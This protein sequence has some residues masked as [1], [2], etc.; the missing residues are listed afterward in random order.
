MLPDGK[1]MVAFVLTMMSDVSDAPIWLCQTMSQLRPV[2]CHMTV[3]HQLWIAMQLQLPWLL[4]PTSK[5]NIKDKTAEA[6]QFHKSCKHVL[7]ANETYQ[8]HQAS[9][10]V[11]FAAAVASRFIVS[12]SQHVLRASGKIV[13]TDISDIDPMI[14]YAY[15]SNEA[16]L[17]FICLPEQLWHDVDIAD[18]SSFLRSRLRTLTPAAQPQFLKES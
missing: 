9:K 16:A 17:S 18:R 7:P 15:E 14:C 4:S 1:P 13:G 3:G 6:F 8:R 11:S 5:R 2:I 10:S 12:G